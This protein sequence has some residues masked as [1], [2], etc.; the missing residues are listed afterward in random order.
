MNKLAYIDDVHEIIIEKLY[1]IIDLIS[2]KETL[3]VYLELLRL[4]AIANDHFVEE[5]EYMRS[6]NY[7]YIDE[8][9][10]AHDYIMHKIKM[11]SLMSDQTFEALDKH[12]NS[13]LE[14]IMDHV[15]NHDAKLF[16]F[17]NKHNNLPA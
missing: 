12:I 2:R 15:D 10:M 16:E 4:R 6:I 9:I 1:H 7:D 13:L 3:S 5:E 11:L 17:T 14:R 8:H